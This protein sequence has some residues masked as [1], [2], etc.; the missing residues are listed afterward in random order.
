MK[1]KYGWDFTKEQIS[2]AKTD[3]RGKIFFL[4]LCVDPKTKS[5]YQNIDVETAFDSLLR[6]LDGYNKLFDCPVEV[7]RTMCLLEA[8]LNEYKKPDF[9]FSIY[10]KLVLDAGSEVLKIKE[11]K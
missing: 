2:D 5:E 3:L 1:H 7:V 11:V 10:R 8:A 6:N 9:Q 4:L